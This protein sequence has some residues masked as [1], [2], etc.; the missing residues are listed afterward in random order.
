MHL[1]INGVTADFKKSGELVEV[2]LSR[3][4]ELSF[5]DFLMANGV[6]VKNFQRTAIAS[7]VIIEAHQAERFE[8]LIKEYFDL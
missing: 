1:S 4:L 5:V 7:R 2:T 6:D 8:G 3:R